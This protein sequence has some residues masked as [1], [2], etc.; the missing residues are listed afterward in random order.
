MELEINASVSLSA[1]TAKSGVN[2][3]RH[4]VRWVKPPSDELSAGIN[5][6]DARQTDH[7]GGRL[8]VDGIDGSFTTVNCASVGL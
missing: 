5:T 4:E 3:V 1:S 8:I 6:A 2:D 7:Q